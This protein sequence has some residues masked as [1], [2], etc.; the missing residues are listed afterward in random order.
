METKDK[1]L[2][3]ALELFADRGY[4]AVSVSQIAQ[5]VGIRA[6]S[7]YKH[8]QS[9]QDIFEA[10]LEKMQAQYALQAEKLRFS[11]QD[12]QKDGPLFS[13]LPEDQLLQMVLGLFSYFLHDPWTARFRRMLTVEQFGNPELG[14]LYSEL[15]VD[16]PFNYQREMFSLLFPGDGDLAALEFYSPIY[17]L[18]TLCD[19]EPKREEEALKMLTNH[20]RQFCRCHQREEE[21]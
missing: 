3:A 9:K 2:E 13:S 7:L 6:P 11:G 19:R 16:G 8:Y 17:L 21:R 5:A 15:Y 4:Q 18:L 1:I 12:P 20:V 14:K 10:I